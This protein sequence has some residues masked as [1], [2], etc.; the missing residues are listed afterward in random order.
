MRKGKIVAQGAHASLQSILAE[1]M[2]L[3]HAGEEAVG[4]ALGFAK[5]PE[6]QAWLKAGT[7][8][9]CVYVESENDLLALYEKAKDAKL[10]SSLIRD[11]GKTEFS[12]EPTY[13]AVAIGPGETEK[14]DAITQGLPLL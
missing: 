5:R 10:M 1:A 9:I 2:Q 6:L 4:I 8:K 12:G 7:P 11:S 3:A 13:T 14:I